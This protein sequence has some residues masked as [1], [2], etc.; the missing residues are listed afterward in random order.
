[1]SISDQQLREACEKLFAAIDTNQNGFLEESEVR[2]YCQQLLQHTDPDAPFNEEIFQDTFK[3]MDKDHNGC[4]S[5][6]E[7]LTSLIEKARE[8]GLHD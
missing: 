5:K 7:L 4:V 8:A 1:M 2:V 6:A 3:K